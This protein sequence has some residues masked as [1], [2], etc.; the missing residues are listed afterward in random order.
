MSWVQRRTIHRRLRVRALVWSAGL[1]VPLGAA[2]ASPIVTR[3]VTLPV[4]EDE[5]VNVVG[6]GANQGRPEAAGC[7]IVAE[8]P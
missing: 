7:K 4:A 1:L 3:S 8:Y 5:T 6:E 2:Q